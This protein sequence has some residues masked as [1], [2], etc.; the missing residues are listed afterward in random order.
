MVMKVVKVRVEGS[1]LTLEP[2]LVNKLKQKVYVSKNPARWESNY[3]VWGYGGRGWTPMLVSHHRTKALATSAAK[4]LANKD[5]L[6]ILG[7]RK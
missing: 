3:S 1:T 6:K 2:V 7:W 4:R 5:V